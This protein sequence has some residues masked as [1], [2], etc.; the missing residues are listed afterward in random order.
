MSNNDLNFVWVAGDFTG[1][2]LE[3]VK[4]THIKSGIN[5]TALDVET[6]LRLSDKVASGQM[7]KQNY[8]R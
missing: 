8:Q 7:K 5:G 3:G 6:L 1:N 4:N 2:Y